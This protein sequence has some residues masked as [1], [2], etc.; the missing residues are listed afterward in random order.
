[1]SLERT[2]EVAFSSLAQESSDLDRWVDVS[3]TLIADMGNFVVKKLTLRR[4]VAAPNGRRDSSGNNVQPSRD[5]VLPSTERRSSYNGS[6]S[7]DL[8]E[9]AFSSEL[10]NDFDTTLTD[11]IE[12]ALNDPGAYGSRS[13]SPSRPAHSRSVSGN[14]ASSLNTTPPLG[15]WKDPGKVVVGALEEVVRSVSDDLEKNE[16][17]QDI[18]RSDNTAA[19]QLAEKEENALRE[20]VKRWLRSVEQTDVW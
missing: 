1:M 8:P 20:G 14:I 6:F 2:P 11:A 16:R 19:A 10:V 17:G 15:S 9:E 13:A 18:P 7:N 5:G 12:R 4:K 3:T